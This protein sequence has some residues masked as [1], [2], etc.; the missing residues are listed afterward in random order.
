MTRISLWAGEL[1]LRVQRGIE[2]DEGQTMAEY[3]LILVLVAVAAIAAFKLLGNNISSKV[4][5]IAT[6][7]GN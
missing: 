6:D 2:R 7:I 1:Y 4:S 3:A 5:K